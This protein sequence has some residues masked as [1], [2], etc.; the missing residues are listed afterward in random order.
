MTTQITLTLPDETYRRAVHLARL[1]G[2]D[3]AG[4]FYQEFYSVLSFCQCPVY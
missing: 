4:G 3:I 1:T 2:R